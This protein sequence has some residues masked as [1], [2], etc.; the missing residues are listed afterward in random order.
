M[1]RIAIVGGHGAVARHLLTVL[2]RAEHTP[3]ALVRREEY[4]EELEGRGAEVRLL[5]IEQQGAEAF[6]EAFEGCDAVVFAA[7]GGPDGNVERKR[8]VDLEGSLKSIQGAKQ[9]GISRFVQVSAIG[10][11]EPL[12]ADTAEVWAAYVVAKRDADAALR[13]SGLAWT[14]LRPG[15]LTDDPATGRVT[16][17]PEVPRGDVTRADVAAVIAAVLDHDASIGHQWEL[18]N[19]S[20]P[21]H[22]ALAAATR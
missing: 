2:R 5:D 22:D 8:T 17:A 16:L 11:D 9:A 10:V 18:V 20:T 3:V 15:R 7:G 6:A 1:S 13:D 4:R 12:L 19:G 14:I 21:V